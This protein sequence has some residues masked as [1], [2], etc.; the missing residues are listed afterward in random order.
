MPAP[1]AGD[2]IVTAVGRDYADVAPIDGDFTGQGAQKIVEVDARTE[3]EG[4]ARLRTAIDEIELGD[5]RRRQV[6]RVEIGLAHAPG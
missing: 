4:R 5:D 3:W 2:H 6:E 1:M